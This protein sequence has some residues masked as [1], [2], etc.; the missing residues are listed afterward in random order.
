MCVDPV[1]NASEF[2]EIND[3]N[4]SMSLFPQQNT[5]LSQNAEAWEEVRPPPY[6][7]EAISGHC[8]SLN[9]RPPLVLPHPSME[10]KASKN[11]SR[12]P[13]SKFNKG[14]Y[15]RLFTVPKKGGSRRPVI[16]LKPLN[17]F[18]TTPKFRMASVSTI[19]RI[20]QPRD[21]ATSID[22]KDAFF[23]I[24]IHNRFRRFLRFIWKGKAYQF[25]S[26]PFGLS[27]APYTFTRITRPIMHWCRAKGIRVVF[28]LDDILILASSAQLAEKHTILLKNMLM[29]LGFKINTKKS[30]F[31]PTQF[32]T[33]LGLT[34]DTINMQ[35]SLPPEKVNELRSTAQNLLSS[36]R[37]TSRAIQRFLGKANFASIA[38]PQG[39]LRCRPLQRVCPKGP[40]N[41]FRR[42]TLSPEAQQSLRWWTTLKETSSPLLLP[43]PSLTLTTDSSVMGWGATLS[44]MTI[45]GKWPTKWQQ[46]RSRHIN[47]LEMRA[48]L[49][50]V[51]HWPP[52]MSHKTVQLL[53]D[54]TATVLYI[55]KEGGTRSA[56]LSRLTTQILD[57]CHK[58]HIALIP[59]HLPG[60]ANTCSDALS[61]QK[62]QDEWH[63][64]PNVA[65][66]IFSILGSPQVDLFASRLTNQVEKYFTLDKEDRS[67]QGVDAF[68][69]PWQ[70][71]VMYAFPPPPLIL[72][73][74]QKFRILGGRMILIAPFWTEAP[75]F[76]EVISLL[77]NQPLRLRFRQNLVINTKTGRPLTNLSRL[78]LTVWPLFRTSSQELDTP[79]KLLNSSLF[80][81]GGQHLANTNRFGRHGLHGVRLKEWTQLRFL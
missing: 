13:E 39:R 54:N 81:G 33:Y 28:Y 52:V 15:S 11:T 80:L 19:A 38:V 43:E 31:N 34:W 60:L 65:K 3:K 27:T 8:L 37:P 75:W 73:M 70:F 55:K 26:T 29:R 18:I 30:D 74:I 42:V 17:K 23:H 72:Q 47:E 56:I 25:R 66:K 57:L 9:S 7:K 77:E 16:N 6:V 32:F 46:N 50:A 67:S 14:F 64:N 24:P 49:H 1:K 59:S 69:H 62:A 40:A 4:K 78:R 76:Q 41:L 22:L 5:S 10:T 20:I 36:D 45:S 35:V 61:R 53:A 44:N 48:V 58:H 68:A 21:W 2:V 12:Y 63:L 51:Q 71:Q 79:R